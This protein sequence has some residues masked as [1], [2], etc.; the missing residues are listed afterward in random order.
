MRGAG[1]GGPGQGQALGPTPGPGERAWLSESASVSH[2]LFV[3]APGFLSPSALVFMALELAGPMLG[4]SCLSHLSSLLSGPGDAPFWAP[5]QLPTL[6][7]MKP[8]PASPFHPLS[9]SGRQQGWC[10]PGLWGQTLGL[11]S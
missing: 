10:V 6:W 8:P 4:A 11:K 1:V 3:S 7:L 2:F 5:R 9:A